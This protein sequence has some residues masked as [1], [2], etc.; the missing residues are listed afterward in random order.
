MFLAAAPFDAIDGSGMIKTTT[1]TLCLIGADDSLH[2]RIATLLGEQAQRLRS[3]W[4]TTERA[5]ADLL[6]VDAESVY[7]HMDWLREKA[8]G[9]LVA[10]CAEQVEAYQGELCLP[11]PVLAADLVALLNRAGAQLA[12]A[13]VAPAE[14]VAA[15]TIAAPAPPA[16]I[17]PPAAISL[18]DLLDGPAAVHQRTRLAADGRPTVLL[19]PAARSWYAEGGLKSL[20]AWCSPALAPD[21]IRTLSASEFTAASAE[22]SAQPYA[23]LIWLGHLLRSGGRLDARLDPTARY[24]LAAW[25]QSEREFPKHFRIATAMLREAATLEE[26]AGHSSATPADVADFV[27]AYHAVGYVEVVAAAPAAEA[28]QR[29]LFAR[30]RKSSVN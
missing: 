1:H 25:P 9:R 14:H 11:K 7:G 17:P 19:D 29:G 12:A 6:L 15:E 16:P 27:N 2:A 28:T 10:A 4:R 30:M 13:G 8:N 22:L 5:A 24:K 26:I 21:D 3:R 18:L 23:R 20:G